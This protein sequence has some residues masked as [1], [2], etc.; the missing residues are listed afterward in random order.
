MENLN[1]PGKPSNGPLAR[2]DVE[3]SW[4]GGKN[5]VVAEGG[6][7]IEACLRQ[8][9]REEDTDRKHEPPKS[10]PIVTP[11]QGVLSRAIPTAQYPRLMIGVDPRLRM[12]PP[13]VL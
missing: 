8:W 7:L 2:F 10:L 12:S 11:S 1:T 5:R 6:A 9:E 13:I 4:A 3:R